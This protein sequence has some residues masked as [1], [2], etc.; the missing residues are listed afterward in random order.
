[1]K[2][3]KYIQHIILLVGGAA[4]SWAAH[5]DYVGTL[6]IPGTS[7]ATPSSVFTFSASSLTGLTSNGLGD[8][9]YRLKL[10]YKYSR[11][12]S[13]ESEYV[14]FGTNAGTVF[15]SPA[16][17]ASAFRQSGFGVDTVATV[18][19]WRQFSF[20]GR[21]GAYTGSR[22]VFGTNPVS[23]L[24][25]E[26]TRGTRL[27]YGL[28]MRYD[29]TKSLGVRAE[30]ERYSPLGSTVAGEPEVDLFSVGLMWRF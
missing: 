3:P 12:L 20:Y 18:P 5:A 24:G 30:M 2:L 23:L 26:V 27:R 16:N 17:L 6:K 14:D 9:G 13:V 10:G 28:G 15:S 21:L 22:D 11:Y 4:A 1:M 8:N 25:G 19:L 29:L 7:G